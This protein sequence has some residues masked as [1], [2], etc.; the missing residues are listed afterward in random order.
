MN[1]GWNRVVYKCWSPIYDRFFNSGIFLKARKE[2]FK[3]LSHKK[4]SSVLFVGVGTGADIPFFTAKGYSITAIDYSAEML[5][6]AKE[7]YPDSSINFLEMDAQKM[8]FPDESFD[9]IVASLILSVVPDPQK[10]LNEI[11]RVVKND[12]TFLIFDK[13]VPNNKKMMKK[14]RILRPIVKIFG[15]DIGLDFYDLYKVVEN[16]CII[17]QDESVMMNGMYRKIIGIKKGTAQ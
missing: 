15:T 7:K 10:T 11:V 8:E 2:I 1:N 6:V 17:T 13:F 3:D 12:G 16:K 5:K 14:Q 9:F 4:G